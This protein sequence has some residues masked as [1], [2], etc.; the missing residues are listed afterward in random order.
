MGYKVTER[1]RPRVRKVD[2]VGMVGGSETDGQPDNLIT[3]RR[4]MLVLEMLADTGE[5]MSLSDI[6]KELDV[7]KSIALRILSTLEE[8][9]YL[10]RNV[11][12]KRFYAGYK[13]S[14]VGLRILS[15]NRLIEQCQPVVRRLAEQTGELVLFSVLDGGYPRKVMA[16][17]GARRRLQVDPTTPFEP[18]STATGKAWL[19]TLPDAEIQGKLH[20]PLRALTEHTITDMAALMEQVRVIRA[21]GIS[22]SNQENETGIAAVATAIWRKEEDGRHCVGF[23][24]VTAPLA[25]ASDEDFARYRQLVVETAQVLGEGWPI[26]ATADFSEGARQIPTLVIS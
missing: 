21:S 2:E 10:Y 18:H 14:N 11:E 8:M 17:T 26:P 9:S 22:F 4:T 7:N 16:V 15:R 1:A 20:L 13:I 6:A 25:R 3:V 19:A 23:V 24:S 12:N 5:G